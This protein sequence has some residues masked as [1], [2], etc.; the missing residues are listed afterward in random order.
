MK[1]NYM[2]LRMM[3]VPIKL[4]LGVMIL[5][6]FTGLIITVSSNAQSKSTRAKSGITKITEYEQD[7]EK[8]KP[9]GKEVISLQSFYDNTGRLIK[10]IEYKEGKP[11]KTITMVYDNEGRRTKEIE[12]N[13]AGKVTKTID[14]KYENGLKTERTTTDANQQIK[15]KRFYK[16]ET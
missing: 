1:T 4:R 15:I 11:D 3:N 10:E 8:G 6:T 5:F 16:Y 2:I 12:T 9:K 14:Y 7:Y 13:E